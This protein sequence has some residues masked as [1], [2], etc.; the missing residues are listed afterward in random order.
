MDIWFKLSEKLR[1][2]IIGCLNAGISYILY[3]IFCLIFGVKSYQTALLLSWFVSSFISFYLQK[4][5]VFQSKCKYFEGY[6]KCCLS[7][8]I[9]YILNA[10]LLEITVKFLSLNVFLAQILSTFC[11]AIIT[12]LLFKNFAFKDLS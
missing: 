9:S 8:C 4:E 10:V 6:I 12:Y 1:F 3:A 5:L 11:V 7:W 2:L